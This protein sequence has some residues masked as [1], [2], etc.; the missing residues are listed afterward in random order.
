MAIFCPDL[1]YDSIVNKFFKDEIL[2]GMILNTPK[3][4]ST[5]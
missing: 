3:T 4:I 1:E 2:P 5:S